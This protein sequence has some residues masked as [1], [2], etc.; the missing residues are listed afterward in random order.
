MA[1]L[2][3]YLIIALT[4]FIVAGCNNGGSGTGGTGEEAGL[5]TP[6]RHGKVGGDLGAQR[7][8]YQAMP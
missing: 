3:K 6:I 8:L 4:L 2:G 7:D 1:K 5:Y